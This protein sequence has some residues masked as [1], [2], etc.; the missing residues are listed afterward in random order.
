MRAKGWKTAVIAALIIWAAGRPAGYAEGEQV[1]LIDSYEALAAFSELVSCGEGPFT[2]SVRLTCSIEAEG[3]F[4]PIGSPDRMFQ[5]SF[6]GAGYEISGLRIEGDRQFSGLF[7]YVGIGGSV[8]NVVLREFRIGGTRY[9][10]GVAGYSMGTIE[11]CAVSDGQVYSKSKE[12]FGAA[13]GGVVG[14]SAGIIRRCVSLDTQVVGRRRVGGIAGCQAGGRIESCLSSAKVDAWDDGEAMAGGVAG[15]VQTGGRV[16]GCI[17]AGEVRAPRASWA[18]GAAGALLSGT[19]SK[20]MFLGR[21]D[22]RE[23]GCIAGYASRRSNTAGC[24]YDPA[25]GT[26]VGEGRQDGTYAFLRGTRFRR[27]TARLLPLFGCRAEIAKL[28]LRPD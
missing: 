6:D 10:G 24:M 15:A 26:G 18:G 4:E 12:E 8:K 19:L 1:I 5:G 27:N 11:G 21:C 28:P 20:C 16:S 25:C 22:G 2:G 14:L 3:S 7:G 17:A 23:P 9:A 13:A